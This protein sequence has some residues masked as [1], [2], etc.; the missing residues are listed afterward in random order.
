MSRF[1]PLVFLQHGFVVPQDVFMLALRCEAAGIRLSIAPSG[2]LAV[3]GPATADVLDQLKRVKPHILALL[4]YVPSDVHLVDDNA[5]RPEFG[6]E[7]ETKGAR[8]AAP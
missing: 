7:V 2:R 1:E 3:D 6:P 4:R 8:R 5:Q